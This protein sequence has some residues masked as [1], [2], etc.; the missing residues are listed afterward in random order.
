[1]RKLSIQKDKIDFCYKNN[2]V[3][4]KG[5]IMK[6]ITFG[7]ATVIIISGIASLSETSK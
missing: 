7:V 4:F 5:D 1:M 6:I 2:C 3:S